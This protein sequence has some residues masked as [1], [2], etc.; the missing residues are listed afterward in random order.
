MEQ[1]FSTFA[2]AREHARSVA[3]AE[4]VI[5]CIQ[6]GGEG[7]VVSTASSHKIPSTAPDP[8]LE[9]S[10]PAIEFED[11]VVRETVGEIIIS[12]R[13]DLLTVI[14]EK[15]LMSTLK[16][17]L[18]KID[19]ELKGLHSNITDELQEQVSELRRAYKGIETFIFILEDVENIRSADEASEYS[20]ELWN[21][22]E[23][24]SGAEIE[25][26]FKKE[27]RELAEKEKALP[28]EQKVKQTAEINHKIAILNSSAPDCRKC[29]SSMVLRE[30]NGDYFWGCSTFPKCFSRKRLKKEEREM[31][32]V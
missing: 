4:G 12:L 8:F 6:R 2:E 31:L 24:F 18:H 11:E 10:G 23:Y 20:S 15:K 25:K 26:R 21:I 13:Q 28:V 5:A 29:G 32:G 7:Y 14:D 16:L 9:T 22:L 27:I 17:G 30:G 1:R 3:K 19:T